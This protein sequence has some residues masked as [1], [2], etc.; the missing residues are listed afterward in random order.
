MS[1]IVYNKNGIPFDIDT[2]ATDLNGKADRD[3]INCSDTGTSNMAHAAMPSDTY[4]DLTLGASGSTFVATADGW[5]TLNKLTTAAGQY[6]T[7]INNSNQ[8]RTIVITNTNGYG[9]S[10]YIPCSKGDTMTYNYTAAG[11]TNY[12]RFVYCNGSAHE[13]T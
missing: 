6:I 7:L 2:I 13:A 12:F 3:L 10:C 5:L 9:L 4:E 1:N 11:T 8:L